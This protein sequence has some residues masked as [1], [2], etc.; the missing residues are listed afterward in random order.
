[1][2]RA[3]LAAAALRYAAQ[4]RTLSLPRSNAGRM[5]GMAL[6]VP[7]VSEGA[8]LPLPALAD[9]HKKVSHTRGVLNQVAGDKSRILP[10]DCFRPSQATR[11]PTRWEPTTPKAK[12][13]P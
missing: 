10:L 2:S 8:S 7:I 9:L 11:P 12:A 3:R 5:G 4:F 1:M 6:P 13:S